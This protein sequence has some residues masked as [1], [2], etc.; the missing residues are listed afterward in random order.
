MN[1]AL[2]SVAL[3]V[4]AALLG[5]AATA[6]L[7]ATA[8]ARRALGGA[9][10]GAAVLALF[11]RQFLVAAML[12]AAGG[13]LLW[14]AGG[15]NAPPG[16]KA[17]RRGKGSTARTG[18]LTMRLDHAT[19]RMDGEVLTGRFA[20][21]A[22][23]T[24]TLAELLTLAAELPPGDS[25]SASLLR[26]YLDRAHPAWREADNGGGGASSAGSGGKA[27]SAGL[28][29][30]RAEA[31]ETLGLAEGADRAAIVAAHR[32]IMK[33][34]HPDLGGSAALA[35]RINAAKDVLLKG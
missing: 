10:V 6:A 7:P 30:S 23:S 32:R 35:A 17:G 11:M 27:R 3:A 18:V 28:E 5:R 16:M 31:L 33:R 12:A 34:V 15:L 13:A 25:D 29:M 2:L 8:M 9:A 19:G 22:L 14:H 21:R 20:G 4:A 26:A 1:A 24:M